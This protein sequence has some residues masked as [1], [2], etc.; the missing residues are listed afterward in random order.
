M[1][2]LTKKKT[3]KD[4]EEKLDSLP[5]NSRENVQAALNNFKKFIHEKHQSTP[6]QIYGELIKK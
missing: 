5:T 1:S 2:I 3:T 4:Y 6:D